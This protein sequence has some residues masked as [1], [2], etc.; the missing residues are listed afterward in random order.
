MTSHA[1]DDE[2]AVSKTEGYKAGEKKTLDEYAKLGMYL[3]AFLRLAVCARVIT[4][5]Q[6]SLVYEYRSQRMVD[7]AAGNI[8]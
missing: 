6:Y 2:L 7:V 3:F 8:G 5:R 4:V 1:N